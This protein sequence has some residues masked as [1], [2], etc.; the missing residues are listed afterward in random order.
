M[1]SKSFGD[2][3][4]RFLT[5]VAIDVDMPP[6]I[7][8][9]RPHDSVEVRRIV[10]VMCERFYRGTRPRLSI[11]GI[12]P[13]RLGAGLTGLS[14]TDPWAVEHDLGIET[15]IT[16]RREISAEFI[17]NVIRSYGGP[18][19]FYADVYLTAFCPLGFVK[20]ETNINFYDDPT[21]Q[22]RLTPQMVSWMHQQ[23]EAGIRPDAAIVL[24]TG[25]LRRFVEDH[26]RQHVPFT[27][28]VYLEHPRYIMQYKRK[29]IDE[30][31]GKYI[32]AIRSFT[33]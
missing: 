8:V 6:G 30:Y 31:V 14:F 26:I 23:L 9:L 15:A 1:V 10:H 27:R 29:S 33:Q 7:S 17:S 21:L 3:V 2:F 5:T 28:V 4:E 24:G 16:G 18:K 19:Q 13:G 22:H 25:A 11:W 20:D 12:N 32:D